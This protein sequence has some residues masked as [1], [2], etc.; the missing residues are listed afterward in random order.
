MD[1]YS[2]I[3]NRTSQTQK[4]KQKINQ[5]GNSNNKI[6]QDKQK[7]KFENKSMNQF[8]RTIFI[9]KDNKKSQNKFQSR[10]SN[11]YNYLFHLK[12]GMENNNNSNVYQ[13][14]F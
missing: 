5:K 1:K 9:N 10:K 4:E 3:D 6:L 2:S 11:K 12:D 8:N 7:Y 14:K 13:K